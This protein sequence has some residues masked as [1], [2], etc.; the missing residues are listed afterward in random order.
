MNLIRHSR[1]LILGDI[2]SGA[3]LPMSHGLAAL[4]PEILRVQGSVSGKVTAGIALSLVDLQSMGTSQMETASPWTKDKATFTGVRLNM[5]YQEVG[6]FGRVSRFTA[7][8]DDATEILYENLE[9]YD[10][11]LAWVH[12]G[13]CTHS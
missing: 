2:A 6:G 13:S 4:S 3:K 11:L 1:R 7:I 10:P 9:K 12:S 8:N 5:L